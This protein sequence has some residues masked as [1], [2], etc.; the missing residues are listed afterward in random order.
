MKQNKNKTQFVIFGLYG[1]TTLCLAASISGTF[2]WYTYSTRTGLAFEGAS[3]SDTGSLHIGVVSRLKDSNYAEYDFEE[4]YIPEIDRYIYWSSTG[5]SASRINHIISQN[6]SATNNLH[7]VT[8]GKYHGS[9]FKLYENP[10]HCNNYIADSNVNSFK[11]MAPTTNYVTLPLVFRYEDEDNPGQYRAGKSIFMS[12][13]K[14]Q[15]ATNVREGVRIYSYENTIDD[16]F[17]INPTEYKDGSDVVGG[18]L[19]LD[20]NDYYDTWIDTST[21]DKKVCEYPYGEFVDDHYEYYSTPVASSG[22][23]PHDEVTTFIANHQEGT[24][25]LNLEKSIPETSDYLGMNNFLNHRISLS[26]TNGI[27]N[28]GFL[29]LLIYLEGWDESMVNAEKDNEFSMDFT[30]DIS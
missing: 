3:V 14:V 13:C 30:F 23:L 9:D 5:L 28:Y 10:M 1:I 21:N 2:A 27:K 22:T 25:A 20:K 24:Y 6:G 11:R 12:D 17:L 29:N 16:G 26:T 7:Q 19:N 4:E 8:T 15:S 18:V